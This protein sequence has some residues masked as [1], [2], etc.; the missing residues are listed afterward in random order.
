MFSNW[1]YWTYPLNTGSLLHWVKMALISPCQEKEDGQEWKEYVPTFFPCFLY[2]IVHFSLFI[3]PIILINPRQPLVI[4]WSRY[5]CWPGCPACYAVSVAST[6]GRETVWPKNCQIM[7]ALKLNWWQL[8]D[9]SPSTKSKPQFPKS[10]IQKEKGYLD[11]GLSLKSHG[12][13]PTPYL[14]EGLS[15]LT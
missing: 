13:P 8:T 3:F 9:A 4:S 11:S 7:P 1:K 12:H 5:S 15:G 14:L 6:R 2:L 10:Q